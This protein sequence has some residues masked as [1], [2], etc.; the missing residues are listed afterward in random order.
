MALALTTVFQVSKCFLPPTLINLFPLPEMLPPQQHSLFSFTACFNS[1]TH[2]PRATLG[3]NL[4]S[5]TSGHPILFFMAPR[6][7]RSVGTW[8]P[9][10]P[11]PLTKIGSWEKQSLC[12][13][14]CCAVTSSAEW[15]APEFYGGWFL[16][17]TLT[18]VTSPS[19]YASNVG[20]HVI[21]CGFLFYT[22][23]TSM[24]WCDKI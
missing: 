12:R 6:I 1:K 5:K 17:A 11:F 19:Y 9:S 23:F 14:A 3:Q 13:G 4:C 16:G 15:C 10:K 20:L 8:L 18:A 24:L 7:E 21:F 2:F 22:V